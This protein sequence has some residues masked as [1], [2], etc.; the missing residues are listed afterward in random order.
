MA[1][2]VKGV[3]DLATMNPELAVQWHPTKNG[4]LTPQDVTSG[5]TKNVWWLLPYDNSETG[6]HFDFEWQAKVA[7]RTRDPRCPYLTGKAILPGL[8]M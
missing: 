1:K 5:S 3:N 4:K 7:D 2:L 8:A 6:K